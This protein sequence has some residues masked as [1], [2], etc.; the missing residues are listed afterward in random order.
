MPEPLYLLFCRIS[1]H[2]RFTLLA[3]KALAKLIR[4]LAL[5]DE[6]SAMLAGYI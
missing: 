2:R 3:R 5:R 1:P 4:R 6:P